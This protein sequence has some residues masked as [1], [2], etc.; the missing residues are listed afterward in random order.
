M[1]NI[2]LK[3]KKK[4]K[5]IISN[6]CKTNELSP[7]I[8]DCPPPGLYILRENFFTKFFLTSEAST[9]RTCRLAVRTSNSAYIFF[10]LSLTLL[11][12]LWRSSEERWPFHLILPYSVL[13]SSL[14][15]EDSSQGL[16]LKHLPLLFQGCKNFDFFFFK[17]L[18]FSFFSFL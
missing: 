13:H 17:F 16:F 12:Q 7:G 11:L 18:N 14:K 5:Y 10:K 8:P 15:T 4:I 1:S 2:Y 6:Q 3:K 9:R